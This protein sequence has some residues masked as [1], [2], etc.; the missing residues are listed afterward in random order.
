M[1]KHKK[2]PSFRSWSPTVMLPYL[3]GAHVVHESLFLATGD[4]DYPLLANTRSAIL[5][6]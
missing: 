1:A 2:T 6:A 5:V 4:W 3:F